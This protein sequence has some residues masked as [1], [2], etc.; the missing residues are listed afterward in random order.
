LSTILTAYDY[1]TAVLPN[2]SIALLRLSRSVVTYTEVVASEVCP[3]RSR[4]I[5]SSPPLC[6]K[7][8]ANVWRNQCVEA[9]RMGFVR[10]GTRFLEVGGV[11]HSSRK[12]ACQMRSTN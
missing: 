5:A 8:V 7:C 12:R 4:K 2:F 11:M 10:K 3:S 1:S 6:K 9:L